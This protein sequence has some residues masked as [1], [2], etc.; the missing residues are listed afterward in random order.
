VESVLFPLDTLKTRLQS[1]QGLH[2][3]GSFRSLYSGIPAVLIG[4]APGGIHQDLLK[5]ITMISGA[6]LC[7]L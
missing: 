5:F 6:I 7:E 3:S 2:A 1:S 4:S